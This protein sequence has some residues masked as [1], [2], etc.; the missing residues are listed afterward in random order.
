MCVRGALVSC[1][2]PAGAAPAEEVGQRNVLQVTASTS[3]FDAAEACPDQR[4][5][6]DPVAH[7]PAAMLPLPA[8]SP[9]CS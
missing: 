7:S 8:H 3:K 2:A 6:T 1:C 5:G 9:A 4:S